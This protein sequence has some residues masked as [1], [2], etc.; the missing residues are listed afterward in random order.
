MVFV[1][2]GGKFVSDGKHECHSLKCG[3]FNIQL[4]QYP[5]TYSWALIY[6]SLD[7][8]CVQVTNFAILLFCKKQNK[9]KFNC[10]C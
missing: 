10:N 1:S 4:D 5:F 8:F 9:T 6:N 2:H 7:S 3:V